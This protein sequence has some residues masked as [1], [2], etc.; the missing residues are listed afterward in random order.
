[1]DV[2][3]LK[4]GRQDYL[5]TGFQ[6]T[7]I[8]RAAELIGRMKEEKAA[9]FLSFTANMAAS[10]LRGVFAEMC[11]RRFVDVVITTGGSLDHD[12]I[13]T[14]MDYGIGDFTMDDAALHKKGMN[15]LGNVLIKNGCYEFLEKAVRPVF[16][17]LYNDEVVTSP[18]SIAAALGSSVSDKGSFLYWCSKNRIPVFSPGIT[19]S[20]IGLQ[21][22]F[23]K[24]RHP[25]FG[26]DVTKD[27]K[28]LADIALNADKTGAIV[29]GGGISKHHTIGVNLLR[30]G[31]DYA[32]Y[33]TT[34]SPWDG[35]LSG[36][37]TNEAVSW[38]KIAEK[39]RHVTVDCDATIALPLIM[40]KF[41]G[42]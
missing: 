3:D 7:N 4:S 26:I 42:D 27:M 40:E 38:G 24:Q 20:A 25:D 15:R 19:D 35:S 31:L 41:L 34:S 39:A 8:G 21:T 1:M 12:I 5:S 28:S 32:V 16:E 30:G 18:S 37:R 36:A 9:V 11:R 22:Y 14:K 10:G 17:R 23:F 2:E 29:L 13:R 33:V 6:A